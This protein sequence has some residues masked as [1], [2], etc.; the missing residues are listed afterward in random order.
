MLAASAQDA[1]ELSALLVFPPKET[2]VLL[3]AK[4]NRRCDHDF[5]S[6]DI[7]RSVRMGEDVGYGKLA[8]VPA[9]PLPPRTAET[10]VHLQRRHLALLCRSACDVDP[11]EDM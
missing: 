4:C 5:A 10:R 7:R 11:Q 6:V 9:L 8:L 2:Q 3:W 1:G